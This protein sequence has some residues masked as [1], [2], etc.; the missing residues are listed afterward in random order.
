M[1]HDEYDHLRESADR[2]LEERHEVMQQ[3]PLTDAQREAFRAYM[4]DLNRK[5]AIEQGV[6]P[7]TICPQCGSDKDPKFPH[8]QACEDQAVDHGISYRD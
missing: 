8:C 6:D 5:A 4:H 2:A 3:A 1:P 7:D